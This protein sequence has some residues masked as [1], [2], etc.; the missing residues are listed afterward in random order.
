LASNQDKNLRPNLDQ[1]QEFSKN[2]FFE[3]LQK[4]SHAAQD[5]YV[6]F[7]SSW[8][9]GFVR[10]PSLWLVPMDDH[11]VHR[12]DGVFE[13]IKARHGGVW[14]LEAHLERLK[15]SAQALGI[16][17][18]FTIDEQKKIILN[19]LKESKLSEAVVR[20]F[21]S[22][23]PGQF[24]VNPYDSIGSQFYVAITKLKSPSQEQIEKGVTVARTHVAMKAGGLANI[25]TCNYLP[26]VMMKKEAVDRGFD[27][28]VNFSEDGVLGESATEN[29]LIVDQEGF[30]C[31]PL[32]KN[33]LK[34]T[35][36]ARACLLAEQHNL[37]QVKWSVNLTEKDLFEAREVMMAGTTL[38]I[39]PVRQYEKQTFDVGTI[40]R[41]LQKL[42][43][44]DQSPGAELVTKF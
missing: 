41:E 18:P 44:H 5:S 32:E 12:G 28:C 17:L 35:T 8:L 1:L 16:P 43:W 33:I 3:Q 42:I 11:L 9:G 25:K 10:D 22:R 23:G 2:D 40:T 6:L 34:G 30:I 4:T 31:T 26:N 29:I 21:L 19:C 14:L 39:L 15:S 7:Y 38:D 13:A 24:T 27:F 36:M 20:V 37:A